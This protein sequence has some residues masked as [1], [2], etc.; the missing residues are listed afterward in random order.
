MVP[1]LKIKDVILILIS[2]RN[3]TNKKLGKDEEQNNMTNVTT[4]I[5]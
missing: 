4:N 5:K 2:K 1:S 3:Q